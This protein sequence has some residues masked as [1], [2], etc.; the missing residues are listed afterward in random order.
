VSSYSF[1]PQ[2]VSELSRLHELGEMD[3]A[4]EALRQLRVEA[5]EA[6]VWLML[7]EL[8]GFVRSTHRVLSDEGIE[9]A[10]EYL[11]GH[12]GIDTTN[13]KTGRYVQPDNR[14]VALADCRMRREDVVHV[15][16]EFDQ[17]GMIG[18]DQP[19]CVTKALLEDWVRSF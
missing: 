8:R 7:A 10:W 11:L 19:E 18:A 15:V 3:R 16:T 6:R 5:E 17:S 9:S 13:A 2:L 4:V 14:S 12:N 1:I